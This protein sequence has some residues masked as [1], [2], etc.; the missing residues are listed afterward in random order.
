MS[1]HR[2]RGWDEP[3][4]VQAEPDDC[5][6]RKKSAC[7]LFRNLK[8]LG[9]LPSES[10]RVRVLPYPCSRYSPYKLILPVLY[11]SYRLYHKAFFLLPGEDYLCNRYCTEAFV[12]AF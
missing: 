2:D 3:Q 5:D 7:C 10:A 12:S 4:S 8:G 1:S 11:N 6:Q 9:L